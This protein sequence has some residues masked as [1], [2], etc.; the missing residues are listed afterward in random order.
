MWRQALALVSSSTPLGGQNLM[1]GVPIIVLAAALV[2]PGAG[3]TETTAWLVSF[4][5]L[6]HRLGEPDLRLLDARPRDEYQ[7]GHIP[8]A[9]WVDAKAVE[10]MA[11]RPGAL[12]DR[13][14]WE[15][16][17]A[18]M[19][20]TSDTK[21]LVYDANRQLDAAR[22]W[23]LLRYLGVARVGLINGGFPLWEKQG[24][25]V[26]VETPKVVPRPFPVHF[27]RE[28]L[29][30]REDVRAAL[31]QGNTRVIDARSAAEYTGVTKRSKRGGRVPTACH[32]EWATLVNADGQFLDGATLRTKLSEVGVK[33]GAPVI[34]HCQGGGRASVD[35]FVCEWLGFRTRNY[36]LGWSDWGNAQ[37]TPIETGPST[38]SAPR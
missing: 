6:E 32:L 17:L 2:A 34:T 38:K 11:A 13:A 27:R 5:D 23:W 14:A 35:A 20:I 16:W 7:R 1:N 9:A 31:K 3:P 33:P 28:R 19:G 36:Y 10:R 37:D 18:P 29:A 22:L 15:A 8:G 30:D 24:R 4:D 21:V 12:T 26:A 25:P